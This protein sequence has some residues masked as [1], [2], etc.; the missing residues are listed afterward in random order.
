VRGSEKE[1]VDERRRRD[2]RLRVGPKMVKV[3]G[4]YDNE[5]EY[6]P[7]LANLLEL[8]V[9]SVRGGGR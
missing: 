7:R 3:H 4:W 1:V 8:Q 9:G 6:V 2:Q 5:W